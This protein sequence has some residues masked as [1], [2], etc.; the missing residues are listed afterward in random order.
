[1]MKEERVLTI[2]IINWNMKEDL[3]GSLSYRKG[4]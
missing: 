3:M 1:M 2:V 4:P